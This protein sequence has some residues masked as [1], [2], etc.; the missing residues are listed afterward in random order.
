MKDAAFGLVLALQ[1]LTRLPLPFACPWTPATRR[2]AVRCYPLVG[3]LLGGLLAAAAALLEN[4]LPALL[5]AL[6][7]LTLWVALSGGLHLDG[8]MDVADALGSNAPLERK[9]EIMKDPHVGSFGILAL[10]F[11]L[12]WKAALL[13][14]LLDAGAGLLLL[15]V[16][17]LGRLA[18]V[19]LLVVAP[20]A[21]REG[22]AASW[23]RDL[24]LRDLWLAALPL[25]P[26]AVLV[27]GG[28]WLC[29]ALAPFLMLYAWGMLRAFKGIN[30]DIV[31]TAIE[32]GE[33]WLLLVAWSWWSFVTG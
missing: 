32:G 13:F 22:M 5:L 23:K 15:I 25:L 10:V 19:A 7:L 20:A 27:S 28:A 26:L 16:L 18:A 6:A 3:V 30:G 9:W 8:L 11:L 17:G 29:L 2:W 21:R 24:S 33:L 31:G 1:F 14:V 4:L 12:L